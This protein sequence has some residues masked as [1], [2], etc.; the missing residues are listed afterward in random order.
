[1]EPSVRQRGSDA[2]PPARGRLIGDGI[3]DLGHVGEDAPG[4]AQIGLPLG[5]Q[6]QRT[7]GAD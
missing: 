2:Q 7:R 3:L 1:M 6:R 4:G 5:G